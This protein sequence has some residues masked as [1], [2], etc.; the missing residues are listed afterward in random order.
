MTLLQT[1]ARGAALAPTSPHDAILVV[2][3]PQG[4]RL[5]TG[6]STLT[7]ALFDRP[8][9]AQWLALSVGALLFAAAAFLALRYRG[10]ITGWLTTRSRPVTLALASM[11]LAGLLGLGVLGWSGWQMT[12]HDNA[13]CTSCHL[14]HGPIARFYRTRHRRVECHDCHKQSMF[15][16]M[17]ELRLW[18]FERPERVPAHENSV[19]NEICLGCHTAGRVPEGWTAGDE[20]LKGVRTIGSTVG[21]MVHLR[22]KQQPGM[23]CAQ[24][25]ARPT[26]HVFRASN[27]T[28][29]QAGCHDDIT[30]K[31]GRMQGLD[32]QCTNCH[33]F[34]RPAGTIKAPFESR[35][36]TL[37]P[38]RAQ[39][40]AC[41]Q[42]RD[43]LKGQSF[44]ADPH[45]EQCGL[46]HNP[47]RQV[48]AK[49]AAVSCASGG[50]HTRADTL[51]S[52]HLGLPPRALAHCANCHNPHTWKA[53]GKVCADCHTQPGG[54]AAA[55]LRPI[56][57]AAPPR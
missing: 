21:H 52:F 50:C 17:K 23:A 24:C 29:Q 18:V 35:E 7:R 19:P 57:M 49:V 47:H 3:T 12:E 10:A 44:S 26:T 45:R 8:Q 41:H 36:R 33:D 37:L 54:P 16:S 40:E 1:G 13:F 51:S 2:Q 56:T 4:F 14:M 53:R 5:P 27:A 34:M 28:C 15:A 32:L 46:C 38:V 9:E 48:D 30:V 6:A 20:R 11:A 25:H 42:M 22:S 55:N 31:L 39:C 43:R